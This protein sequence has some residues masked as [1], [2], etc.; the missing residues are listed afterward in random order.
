MKNPGSDILVTMETES[1]VLRLKGRVGEAVNNT[2]ESS[3]IKFVAF[4]LGQSCHSY[5]KKD[6]ILLG[7]NLKL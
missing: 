7:I 6:K 2:Q 3:Q 4:G 1:L 5:K